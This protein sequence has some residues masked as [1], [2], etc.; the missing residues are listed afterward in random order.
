MRTQM[1]NTIINTKVLGNG[2][3]MLVYRTMFECNRPMTQYEVCRE[4]ACE[5]IQDRS[6]TPLFA[7]LKRQGAIREVGKR[8]CEHTDMEVIVW[9]VTN[10]MP[11]KFKR[12][13]PFKTQVAELKAQVEE[14]TKRNAQLEAEVRKAGCTVSLTLKHSERLSGDLSQD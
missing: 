2:N 8:H 4:I 5:S 6:L 10:D 12:E 11:V 3:K 1:L 14:L 7:V 13:K 9:E